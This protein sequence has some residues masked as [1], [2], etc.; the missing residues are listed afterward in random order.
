MD[1]DIRG[2]VDVAGILSVDGG[3]QAIIDVLNTLPLSGVFILFFW[4][5]C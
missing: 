1:A 3:N 2:I 5:S 4:Y